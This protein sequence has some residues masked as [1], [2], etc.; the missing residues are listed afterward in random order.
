MRATVYHGT[1]DVRVEEVP[2]ATLREPTDALVRVTHA[3]ICGSDLW[4]YRGELLIYGE[5][6]RMGH[7]FMGV[8]DAVGAEVRTLAPGDRVI[9]PFAFSD[10]VCEY[11]M[12]G[13][14][15]SCVQGGYWG[16]ANDGGQGEA[17]RAPLA[18]GT[19][20][21][22]PDAVDLSDTRLATALTA[23]TDVAGTGHHAAVSAGVRPGV[24]AVVVGD[25]AVG[26]CG[27][28]AAS[29]L[30]AER[31]IV[32][33]RHETRLEVAR[34]F[35][36]TDEVRER[37]EE[38]IARVRELT[39][40]GA[41]HVLECVGTAQATKTAIAVCRPGGTVGHVG[42]P[43]ESVMLLDLYNRNIAL[44][45]GVAPVRAY[46]PELL[47]DVLAG[48]IDPSPVLD[49]TVSL[50]EVPQG[51]AAMDERRAIKVLVAVS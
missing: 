16:T 3:G 7:E 21:K 18:D 6:G 29:R 19:L 1:R 22:L 31:I 48:R 4:P 14:H 43:A 41:P 45:G 20:V 9:A 37:G 5:H 39:G 32:M 51:Y 38:G 12:A 10:G 35:G 30:G 44:R 28:L 15:T 40:G 49:L 8:V 13:L 27:T 50:D 23:L 47:Q 2:D 17:V 46:I 26:L 33:G 42:V 24:T 36:A 34:R 11:C 25:G